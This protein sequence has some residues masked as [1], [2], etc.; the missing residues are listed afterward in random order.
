MNTREEILTAIDDFRSGR[1]GT[2]PA[3]DLAAEDG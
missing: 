3:V 2:V 1:M